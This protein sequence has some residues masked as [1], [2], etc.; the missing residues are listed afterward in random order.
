MTGLSSRARRPPLPVPRPW[1]RPS[2]PLP[3]DP[4][5][6]AAMCRAIIRIAH[7]PEATQE[8]AAEIRGDMLTATRRLLKEDRERLQGEID[9]VVAWLNRFGMGC[10]D[11]PDGRSAKIPNNLAAHP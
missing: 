1:R 8:W 7:G 10:L 6:L 9:G 4:G 2:P 5:R 11:G 3:A